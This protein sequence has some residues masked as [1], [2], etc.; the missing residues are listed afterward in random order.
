MEDFYY[1]PDPEGDLELVLKCPNSQHLIWPL[2]SAEGPVSTPGG[3][4]REKYENGK[5]L[6]SINHEA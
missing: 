5:G 2:E 1:A 3:E 4:D 6:Q